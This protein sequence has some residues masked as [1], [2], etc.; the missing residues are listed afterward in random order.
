MKFS[1]ERLC[2]LSTEKRGQKK[3]EVIAM[4]KRTKGATLAEIIKAA[5]WQKHAVR[6]LREHPDD[7]RRDRRRVGPHS[8]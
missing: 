5:G 6:G 2:G 3:G 7:H 8:D 4:M 1:R